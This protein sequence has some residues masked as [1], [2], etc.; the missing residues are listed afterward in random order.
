MIG[1]II[2]VVIGLFVMMWSGLL[3]MGSS[4]R[5]WVAVFLGGVVMLILGAAK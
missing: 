1:Q 3:M 2:L 4:D 5:G